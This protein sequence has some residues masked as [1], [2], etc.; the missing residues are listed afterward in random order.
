[1]KYFSLSVVGF[2][3]FFI[4][5]CAGG[6]NTPK[7]PISFYQP[8]KDSTILK[9]SSV[10][11]EGSALI[12]ANGKR[13]LDE[14]G[15]IFNYYEINGSVYYL[16]KEPSKKTFHVKDQ[17]KKIIKTFEATDNIQSFKD[18][19][20]VYLAVQLTG[21][22]TMDFYDNLYEFDGKEFN[23]IHKDIKL[24]YFAKTGIFSLH[25]RLPNTQEDFRLK[26]VR[27]NKYISLMPKTK[28][29][30]SSKYPNA[31][32]YIIGAIG[33]KIFYIYKNVDS[34]TLLEM[35][36]TSSNIQEILLD[37][38]AKFQILYSG[39]QIVLKI[40]ENKNISIDF[41]EDSKYINEPAK[42]IS[43]NSLKEVNIAEGFQTLKVRT[44]FDNL[45]GGKTPQIYIAF[46]TDTL[47]RIFDRKDKEK[48]RS[49]IF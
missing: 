28:K 13:I 47:K 21:N 39:N 38:T 32:T 17:N 3:I 24:D 5:G 29:Y 16:L 4:F 20:K 23:L 35:L 8:V 43:L 10:R 19:N 45:G 40:F 42:Y 15:D 49:V 7:V 41:N 1:M 26:N 34:S 36:D 18:I 12:L 11:L 46:T 30:L 33:Q 9:P 6:A 48:F 31:E 44:S 37:E 25:N 27:D 2:V 22:P 14:Q